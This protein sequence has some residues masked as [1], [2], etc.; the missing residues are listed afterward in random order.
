MAPLSE[1]Y[2]RPIN[3]SGNTGTSQVLAR[4]YR[5]AH[6]ASCLGVVDLQGFSRRLESERLPPKMWLQRRNHMPIWI[7]QRLCLCR[8]YL[9][10]LD[11]SLPRK[12]SYR[13]VCFPVRAFEID[14]SLH[15]DWNEKCHHHT[16]QAHWPIFQFSLDAW[17]WT[18]ERKRERKSRFLLST[19]RRFK[20]LWYPVRQQ[21]K[22]RPNRIKPLLFTWQ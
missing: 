18:D 2:Q 15:T 19:G 1:G 13:S 12:S 7:G 6:I 4:P 20:C 17:V 21:R 16:L 5:H 22:L 8:L 14:A 11:I 9:S 3:H 10:T